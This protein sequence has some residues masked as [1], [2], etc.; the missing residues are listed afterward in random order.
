LPTLAARA[1]DPATCWQTVAVAD[2]YGKGA[3]TVEIVSETALWYHTGLPSVSIRWVLIRQGLCVL[4]DGDT[5]Q[6]E[7]GVRIATVEA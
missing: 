1:D 4:R 3:R 5:E 6:R 2:W 7:G